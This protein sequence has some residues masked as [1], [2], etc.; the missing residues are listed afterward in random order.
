MEET[1]DEYML[2]DLYWNFD[3]ERKRGNRS[4][5][6]IFKEKMRYFAKSSFKYKMETS[7]SKIDINK[8]LE[9]I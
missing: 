2:E 7:I 5:R 4:E 8:K 6:D 3:A 9:I 1:L